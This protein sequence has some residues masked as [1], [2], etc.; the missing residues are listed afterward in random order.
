MNLAYKCLFRL[1]LLLIHSP[2]SNSTSD[3]ARARR[4]Y[5]CIQIFFVDNSRWEKKEKKTEKRKQHITSG[6]RCFF[7]S[8]F[9]SF[10]SYVWK[11]RLMQ[12]ENVLN[13]ISIWSNR[14]WASNQWERRSCFIFKLTAI[15][16][17]LWEKKRNT[18]A[19]CILIR[20]LFFVFHSWI[21]FCFSAQSVRLQDLKGSSSKSWILKY[22]KC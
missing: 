4:F 7:L 3:W 17:L 14:L 19:Y 11:A 21:P 9:I 6:V 15:Y 18:R 1:K 5:F 10:L 8:F 20:L 2:A 22:E 13:I 16:S 12:C